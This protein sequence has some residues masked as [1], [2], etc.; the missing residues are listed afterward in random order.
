MKNT[1]QLLVLTT[2][3][4]LLSPA[5]I[6]ARQIKETSTRRKHEMTLSKPAERWD[7]AMP[8]GNGQ[9]GA[10]V[11]GDIDNE[12]IVLNYDCLFI[13]S[14]KPQLP[15]VSHHLPKIRK[16]L[17]E[18]KYNQAQ[19]FIEGEIDKLYDYR[20]PD[21]YHPA[22]N[23]TVDMADSKNVT[24]ERRAVNFETGEV[25]VS[26]NQAGVRYERRMFV[27]R[28]DDVVVMRISA[29]K[30]AKVNC[31]IGLLPTGL[32]R[33]ELG[34]GK[35]VRIPRFPKDELKYKIFLDKVPITF[36]LTASEKLLTI[37]GKY[38]VG[39]PYKMVGADEFGG[40]AIVI[41]KGG[42]AAESNLQVNINEADEV[43]VLCKLFAHQDS[44]TSI[45]RVTRELEQL[46]HDYAALLQRHNALHQELFLRATLD[47]RGQD[48]YRSMTNA[49][50]LAAV[51]KGKGSK[52][53]MERLFDFGRFTL[54]CSSRPGAKPA[55]LK[56][57]WCGVY[58]PAWSANY[59]NDTN[60]QMSY[61]QALP[62]NIAELTLPYFD[63]YEKFMD[64]FRTNA[65]NIY[66]CRGILLPISGLTTNGLIYKNTKTKN[67]YSNWTAGAGWIAQLFYDYWLYTGDRQFLRKRAVPFM[68]EC[69]LFYEDFLFEGK[70]G[71]YLFS[72]SYSPE[73]TP[74]NTGSMW[75]VN[76]TMDIAV[77]KEL[78]TNLCT[79]C[80]ALGI[81]KEGVICWRRMLA[82]LPDY[83][84]NEE[85]ALKE[86][87]HPHLKDNYGHRHLS[88][89]YPL[90]PG[91]EA[92][93]QPAKGGP[94]L[95][96]ACRRAMSKKFHGEG[97]VTFTCAL[98][99]TVRARLG[100]GDAALHELELLA[101]SPYMLSNLSTFVGTGFPVMQMETSSGISAAII[102]MLLFSEPGTG[103]PAV[104][105]LPALP[106]AWPTG[107]I[108][109]L[110]ARGGFEVDI[111]WNEGKLTEAV[112]CSLLGNTCQVRY[113]KKAVELKTETGKSYRLDS[114]LNQIFIP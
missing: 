37:C 52:A 80:E 79:A 104:K 46:P 13:R 85:G 72:P 103:T 12:T 94:A 42:N 20:G 67:V 87:A 89:L 3:V 21:P 98:N 16:M 113:G 66:G 100:E 27:S 114:N 110:R 18:G 8:T 53:L 47:L 60:I 81:E 71:K 75:H 69:A 84:I 36:N 24:N 55:N 19:A 70:D 9:I 59:H 56:G 25:E 96:E 68:K 102:E 7:F 15:D 26:W 10:M 11:F 41:V 61:F 43:L 50:L 78:L 1:Y 51:K 39:G 99:A 31:S 30:P 62:G 77:T 45:K 14:V 111:Y 63:L 109:G 106:K 107:H 4:T 5:E 22:F 64:D 95:F 32:Q 92:A 49:E 76:A 2:V 28:R 57:I 108:K 65:M 40:C 58:G 23:I 86:W 90:F 112:I 93:S 97:I 83:M 33:N 105:L 29:S 82:K 101:K 34:N 48:N 35:N 91:L 88:H 74:A 6:Y 54:I 73:N 44:N 17:A 38:D